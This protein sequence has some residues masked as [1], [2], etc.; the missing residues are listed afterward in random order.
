MSGNTL[1]SQ[2]SIRR[3]IF[4]NPYLRPV[5]LDACVHDLWL[6]RQ[7]E[8]TCCDIHVW[9]VSWN[10][11]LASSVHGTTRLNALHRFTDDKKM[12]VAL[13]RRHYGPVVMKS[14]FDKITALEC[15]RDAEAY[16]GRF[17]AELET[18]VDLASKFD[19]PSL[20]ARG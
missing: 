5:I 12:V 7:R 17:L 10:L 13:M 16:R 6:D 15:F 14:K 3:V 1:E 20:S 9:N 2:V 4:S 8:I 18:E 19:G 11:G